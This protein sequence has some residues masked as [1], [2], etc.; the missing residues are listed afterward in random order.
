VDLLVSEAGSVSEVRVRSG[1]GSGFGEAAAQVAR[2]LAFE[3]ARRGGRP[4]A[5]WIPWTVKF[6]LD[7]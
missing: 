5:V 3:P 7:G 2:R 4:V 1:A 6:R